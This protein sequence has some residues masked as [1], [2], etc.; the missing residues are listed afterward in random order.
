VVRC[1]VPMLR[2]WMIPIVVCRRVCLW[3][4]RGVPV[5]CRIILDA[6]LPV[7]LGADVP[8]W[9]V[10]RDWDDVL[11]PAVPAL[12]LHPSW[13]DHKD[14]PWMSYGTRA[15]LHPSSASPRG[16]ARERPAVSA[17][18]PRGRCPSPEER[19]VHSLADR[20]VHLD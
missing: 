9:V 20:P 12:P 15:L 13:D 18:P 7:P 1:G 10:Y 3:P 6:R 5:V 2:P 17:A 4:A 8:N 11:V 16:G 14:V 19:M